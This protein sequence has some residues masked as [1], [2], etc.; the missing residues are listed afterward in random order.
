MYIFGASNMRARKQAWTEAFY[1]EFET[2]ICFF[3]R[4]SCFWHIFDKN[5]K[6]GEN[7]FDKRRKMDKSM[8]HS[9]MNDDNLNEVLLINLQC[10][11]FSFI[12]FITISKWI[13]IAN[14]KLNM[15][16]CQWWNVNKLIESIV[17][18]LLLVTTIDEI[19][20]HVNHTHLL[21]I[22]FEEQGRIVTTFSAVCFF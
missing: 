19:E 7:S 9:T 8:T 22:S 6:Y 21:T 15:S 16:I 5:A 20:W 17:C 13:S 4:F 1:I 12:A 11:E 18:S 3:L 10:V 14:D 2:A